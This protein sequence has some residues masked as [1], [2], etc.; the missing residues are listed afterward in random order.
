MIDNCVSLSA[1]GSANF[2]KSDVNLNF[3][4]IT[5]SN[6]SVRDDTVYNTKAAI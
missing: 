4:A 2:P 3:L 5:P 1:N 6:T